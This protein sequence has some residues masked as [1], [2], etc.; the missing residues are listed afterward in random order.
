ME[1]TSGNSSQN[2]GDGNANQNS[3]DGNTNQN[4]GT[5]NNAQN[6]SND[7]QQNQGIDYDKLQSMI[8]NATA[9]KE[10]IVL[11][12]Y[13]KQQG[14]TKEEVKQAV[15]TY[16]VT[17]QQQN[18]QAI[19]DTSELETK[20]VEAQKEAQKAR[21]ELEATKLA[22]SLN[23]DSKSL[24]YVLKVADMSNAVDKDGKLNSE[25]IKTALNK[26]L[27]D[28]PAFKESSGFKIGAPG[29]GSQGGQNAGSQNNIPT[30]R[31]NRFN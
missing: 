31:W 21:V 26:V 5:D 12:D 1:N 29:Q 19:T 20:V 11:R 23:I 14:M 17:R 10:D 8:D 15:D 30:K 7:T 13:F 28:V 22:A 3:G 9:K 18:Q 4:S 16:K 24:P 2:T 25:S 27:E 6:N